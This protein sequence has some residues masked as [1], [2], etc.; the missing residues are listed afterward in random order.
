MKHN[1]ITT[2]AVLDNIIHCEVTHVPRAGCVKL[3]DKL[4]DV[5]ILTLSPLA[6]GRPSAPLPPGSP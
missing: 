5:Q 3:M 1:E 4:L 6:P 2:L